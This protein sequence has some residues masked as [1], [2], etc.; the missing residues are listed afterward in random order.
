M[1]FSNNEKNLMHIIK[2]EKLKKI[3]LEKLKK[4]K[5]IKIINEEIKKININDSSV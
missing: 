4:Q 5:N 1:N 3:F 2:N